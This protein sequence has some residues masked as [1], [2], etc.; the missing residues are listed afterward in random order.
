MMAV[1]VLKDKKTLNST[2]IF[3]IYVYIHMEFI[4]IC[5]TSKKCSEVKIFQIVCSL[6]TLSIVYKELHGAGDGSVVRR[7]YCSF[8]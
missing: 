5:E 8:R 1:K 3:I 2:V 4:L 7:M 6:E